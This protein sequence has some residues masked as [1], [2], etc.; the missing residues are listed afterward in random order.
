MNESL[1]RSGSII[2]EVVPL[3]GKVVFL[4]SKRNNFAIIP[5]NDW[6]QKDGSFHRRT[7]DALLEAVSSAESLFSVSSLFFFFSPPTYITRTVGCDLYI[8]WLAA[9]HLT[10]GRFAA[11][12]VILRLTRKLREAHIWPV[13][14]CVSKG[15]AFTIRLKPTW[16]QTWCGE[17]GSSACK[18]ISDVVWWLCE[19]GRGGEG[20]YLFLNVA[21]KK[22]GFIFWYAWCFDTWLL[23]KLLTSSKLIQKITEWAVIFLKYVCPFVLFGG[24]NQ[25]LH[26]EFA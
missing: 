25:R 11:L 3:W 4:E 22:K 20:I 21:Y 18:N 6:E 26:N 1:Q 5:T 15:R 16:N 19:G 10:A 13:M 23:D 2:G 14:A 8:G 24:N 12:L 7:S 17:K 9:L